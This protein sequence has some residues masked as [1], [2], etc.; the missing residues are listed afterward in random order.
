ML[1]YICDL[2]EVK[3]TEFFI[4]VVFDVQYTIVSD[5]GVSYLYVKSDS[6]KFHIHPSPERLINGQLKMLGMVQELR[7]LN[8]SGTGGGGFFFNIF[9]HDTSFSTV[10]FF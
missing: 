3:H 8:P 10:K 4:L 2:F 6:R 9:R 1:K 7:H 5:T